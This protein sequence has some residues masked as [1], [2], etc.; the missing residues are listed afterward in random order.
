MTVIDSQL[1]PEKGWKAITVREELYRRLLA[2]KG[3]LTVNDYITSLL[4]SQTK[5]PVDRQREPKAR[6]SRRKRVG[7]KPQKGMSLEQAVRIVKGR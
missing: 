7:G 2:S 3:D 4:D 5:A 6:D 1:M